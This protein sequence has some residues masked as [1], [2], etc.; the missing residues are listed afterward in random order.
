MQVWWRGD[1]DDEYFTLRCRGE[2]QMKQWEGV[3]TRLIKDAHQK[4]QEKAEK[5][6]HHSHSQSI[7]YHERIGSFGSAASSTTTLPPY[8]GPPNTTVQRRTYGSF[9]DDKNGHGPYNGG[10][11]YGQQQ[12]SQ[13]RSNE[14][15]NG[16]DNEDDYDDNPR[17]DEYGAAASGRGTPSGRRGAAGISM[18]PERDMA[19]GYDRPRAKTEDAATFAQWKQQQQQ[20]YPGSNGVPN[21]PGR[22][23]YPRPPLASR[24]A[25]AASGMSMQSESSFGNG[26]TDGNW[27]PQP[28]LRHQMSSGKLRSPYEEGPPTGVDRATVYSRYAQNNGSYGDAQYQGNRQS[29]VGSVHGLPRTR[30]IS[31]PSAYAQSSPSQQVPPV[32]I[33]PQWTGSSQSS[34]GGR[35][36]GGASRERLV[37]TGGR[38]P[39]SLGMRRPMSGGSSDTGESEEQPDSGPSNGTL[40][41]SRS[42]IFNG[43]STQNAHMH[44]GGYVSSHSG[45][46]YGHPGGGPTRMRPGVG[47]DGDAPIRIKVYW[48]EDLFVIQVP[49]TV[50]YGEL[51]ARVQ[52][53]IRLCGGGNTEGPLRLKYDDEDGDRI[54]LSTDEELQMAFDMTASRSTGQ[55]QLTLRVN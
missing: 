44:N 27:V 19:P 38:N 12:G 8:P 55:G 51:V 49:R 23:P 5:L 1:D 43:S 33:A 40:R 36:G 25:S 11:Y 48:G 26:G 17:Y 18:P 2:E 30:A 24:N 47:T 21:L 22:E 53:K 45:A 3:I 28:A 50:G 7:N 10:S 15:T 46:A 39:S 34:N 13:Y 31:N 16:W 37:S 52:K 42:Q 6:R 54:S 29:G 20:Q 4:H 14:W 35:N 41:G 9:P 32:P